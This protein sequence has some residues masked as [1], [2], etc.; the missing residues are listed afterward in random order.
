[1]DTDDYDPSEKVLTELIGEYRL[2]SL[3]HAA[4]NNHMLIYDDQGGPGAPWYILP[5]GMQDGYTVDGM[6]RDDLLKCLHRLIEINP[7]ALTNHALFIGSA[8][9][10]WNI[11]FWGC[12]KDANCTIQELKSYDY[13]LSVYVDN[14]LST[15]DKEN[16][17]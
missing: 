1:M 7:C 5:S 12:S 10:F 4:E 16:E 9:L 8:E 11:V 15:T 2:N 6:E 3:K 17:D 14:L 13:N